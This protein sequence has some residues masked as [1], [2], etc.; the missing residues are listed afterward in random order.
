MLMFAMPFFPEDASW[1]GIIVALLGI[2]GGLYALRPLFWPA[3]VRMS[4]ADTVEL[5]IGTDGPIKDFHLGCTFENRGAK[6]GI[7]QLVKAV[8]H[9]SSGWKHEFKWQFFVE[10]EFKPKPGKLTRQPSNSRHAIAVRPGQT[11]L[12]WIQF[13]GLDWDDQDENSWKPGEYD[14]EICIWVNAESYQS[15]PHTSTRF[16]ARIPE[17]FRNQVVEYRKTQKAHYYSLNI[18]YRSPLENCW[19]SMLRRAKAKIS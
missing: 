6:T 2:I 17:R 12:V 3:C 13:E 16:R 19:R 9:N 18:N 15:L 5:V 1:I 7:V 14:F 10:H 11:E 8:V 4:V